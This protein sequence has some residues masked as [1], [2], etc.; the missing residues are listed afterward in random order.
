MVS[1][2]VMIDVN[3][4]VTNAWRLVALLQFLAILKMP[5][6]I[7]PPARRLFDSKSFEYAADLLSWRECGVRPSV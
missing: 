2:N 6:L 4:C 5:G 1:V 7:Q 3:L